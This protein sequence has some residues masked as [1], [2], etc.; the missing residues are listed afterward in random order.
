MWINRIKNKY[1]TYPQQI[2]SEIG[3]LASKNSR[4]SVN[5]NMKIL[6]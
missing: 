2:K 5:G 4:G 6:A 3:G 1:K